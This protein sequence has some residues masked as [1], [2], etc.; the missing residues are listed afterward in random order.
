MKRVGKKT[1][2]RVRVLDKYEKAAK[3]AWLAHYHRAAS[4]FRTGEYYIR[5]RPRYTTPR[6]GGIRGAKDLYE[7]NRR[8]GKVIAVL[9]NVTQKRFP[10]ACRAL[11]DYR[12]GRIPP[13]VWKNYINNGY[14]TREGLYADYS[15][16]EILFKKMVKGYTDHMDSKARNGKRGRKNKVSVRNRSR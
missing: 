13:W 16:K 9:Y 2:V 11:K 14:L 4:L 5:G 8:T 10:V 15:K 7:Y 6:D 1:S 3:A 12:A